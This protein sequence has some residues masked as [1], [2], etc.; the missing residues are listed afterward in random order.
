M[1]LWRVLMMP[2]LLF[3]VSGLSL[4]TFQNVL[5]LLSQVAKGYAKQ[6]P[7]FAASA[8]PHYCFVAP[9]AMRGA[10]GA[11][12]PTRIYYNFLSPRIY[13]HFYRQ[14]L[15]TLTRPAVTHPHPPWRA[16]STTDAITGWL[17][18]VQPY[19]A[20]FV[21]LLEMLFGKLTKFE[22]TFTHVCLV[23]ILIVLLGEF[24]PPPRRDKDKRD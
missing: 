10:A 14:P 19:I 15:R 2:T 13:A 6:G 3:M 5:R 9:A 4:L 24:G 18:A 11:Q 16:A 8:I 22:F 7:F 12:R 20:K 1:E 21:A 17:R 23:A